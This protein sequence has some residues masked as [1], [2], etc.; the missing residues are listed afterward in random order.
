MIDQ[1]E[2]AKAAEEFDNYI[3]N[4]AKDINTLKSVVLILTTE[5]A[6]TGGLSKEAEVTLSEKFDLLGMR[7]V[8]ENDVSK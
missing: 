6:R 1:H 7:A 3:N 5:I 2:F 8:E 4:M